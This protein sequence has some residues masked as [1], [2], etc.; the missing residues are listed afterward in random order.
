MAQSSGSGRGSSVI[1]VIWPLI[2]G[3]A[4][5]FLIGRE[6]GGPRHD[7]AGGGSGSAVAD[8]APAGTKMPAKIYKSDAEFPDGWTKEADLAGVTTF[9]LAGLTA[10]QKVTVLQALNERD[11][12]CGCG[13]GKIAGCIKKDPNCPRSPQLGKKAVDLVKE[14]K[15]LGEILA[16]DRRA[17]EAVRGRLAVAERGRARRGRLEEGDPAAH[18]VRLG[19]AAAKVTIVEFSD[20]ECPFC[21]RV[22]ADGQRRAEEVRQGR[23]AGVGQPAAAV[24]RTTRWAPRRRSRRPRA[25]SPDKA[26]ALH[27]KMFDNF[28]TLGKPE[29]EKYAAEVGLNVAKLKKDWDDPK[30]KAQVEEDQKLAG[31]VGA[32]G[33]PTF[34]INGRELVGAQPSD[35]F[36]T[37][38]DDELKKVDELMKKGTPLERRLQEAARGS[39]AR[40]GARAGRR[41]ARGPRGEARRQA[42]RRAGQGV[43]VREGHGHRLQ[44]LPVPVLLARRSDDEADR[45]RVQGQ[46]PDR[47][48]AAAAAVPRQGARWRRRRRWPRTSRA[49]SGSITT[50]CSP[51][52]RRSTAPSLEKYAEELGLNMS[53]FKA[54]LD[55]GKFKDKVDADAKEGAAVGASGTPDVLHQRHQA[56]SARSR[57]PRSRRSSTKS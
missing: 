57:S 18:N 28:K 19:P 30:I 53:K 54:A 49:S 55:S 12:E 13:M 5:G 20:F 50:S 33:T 26:W 32:N 52:S 27:D 44:R 4:V 38:I 34:F 1:S 37:I 14:G 15:G 51:I 41:R 11:C 35:A 39:G 17:A 42:G 46:G 47:V 31:S 23:R 22:G 56:A 10:P 29:L 48:Q 3:L 25:Q 6:V 36:E 43:G 9:S 8:K 16:R 21:N 24:P 7:G 2:T 45:R 40:A